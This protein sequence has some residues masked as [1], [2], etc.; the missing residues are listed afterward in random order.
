MSTDQHFRKQLTGLSGFTLSLGATRAALR[1][2]LW[3]WPVLAAFVLGGVG[4]WVH[5]SVEATMREELASQLTTILN[6]DVTALRIWAKEQEANARSVAQLSALRSAVRGLLATTAPDPKA[7]KL[8]A[9]RELTDCRSLVRPYLEIFGYTHFYIV[10]PRMQIMAANHD[11]VPM[12]SLADYPRTFVE[13]VLRTGAAV[14][15]PVRA[16]ALL[17]DARGDLKG[18]LPTMFVA[19]VIPD[20]A[21]KPLA[22]LAF[23]LRPE[24]EFSEIL[25][26][27]RYGYSGETYA[28]SETGLLLSQSRFDEDLKPL[29]LLPDLPDSVSVLTVEVRDPGVNMMEGGRPARSRSEQPLTTL[30]AKAVS[31]GDGLVMGAYG[32]YR[33]VPSVGACRWLPEFD[34]AVATEVDVA[35]AFRP[36]YVLRRT[37]WILFGLLLL[38]AVGIFLFMLVVAHQQRR[39]EKAEKAICQLGQYTLEEKIGTGGMGSK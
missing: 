36:L 17:P 23:R 31:D 4:W 9:T 30:A 6:A 29:R 27:A 10:S 20:E 24:K 2:Q 5:G 13:K 21:G 15:K 37:I 32:D 39:M 16:I 33:G 35:D 25:Q 8:P 14:S 34:M 28:F 1:R 7:G 38:S 19:A 26:T 11:N 3:V 22:V 12:T 18:G